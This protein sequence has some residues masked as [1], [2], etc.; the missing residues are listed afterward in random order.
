MAMT[1]DQYPHFH[2]P[3]R[4]VIACLGYNGRGVALGTCLGRQ[5]ARRL[6][7]PGAAVDMPLS[8]VKPIALHSWWPVAV[9]GAIVRGR[10]ADFLGL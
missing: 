8:S 9:R 1:R 6:L 10:I 2:E 7:E 4:G 5:I 3:A